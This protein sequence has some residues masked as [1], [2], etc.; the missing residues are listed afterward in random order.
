MAQPSPMVGAVYHARSSRQRMMGKFIR[1]PD[2]RE[3]CGYDWR[4]SSAAYKKHQKRALSQFRRRDGKRW[5]LEGLAAVYAEPYDRAYD[6][7]Q[8][9]LDQEYSAGCDYDRRYDDDE[10]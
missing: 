1:T 3:Y 5:I 4:T 7:E 9:R 8:D 2:V 10:D 6:E